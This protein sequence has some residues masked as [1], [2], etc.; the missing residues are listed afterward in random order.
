MFENNARTT[1]LKISLSEQWNKAFIKK[2]STFEIQ[3]YRDQ[4]KLEIIR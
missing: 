2:E 1:T 4:T 3:V